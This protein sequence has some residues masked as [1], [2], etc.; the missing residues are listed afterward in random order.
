MPLS[1]I[2]TRSLQHYWRISRGLTLCTRGAV[3]DAQGCFLLIRHDGYDSWHFPG[4]RVDGCE[5]VEAALSRKLAEGPGIRI[6]ETPELFG[7]YADL[8]NSES[9]HIAVFVIRRWHRQAPFAANVGI[10]EQS[11]FAPEA[12][13]ASTHR[14]TRQR[15]SEILGLAPKSLEW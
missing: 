5:T 11:Y 7:I 10:A 4:G 9:R 12:L 6:D 3:I 13:P 15:I 14:S 8:K 1:R 2:V